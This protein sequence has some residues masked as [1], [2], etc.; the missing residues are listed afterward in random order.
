MNKSG[1]DNIKVRCRLVAK[2]FKVMSSLQLCH[3]EFITTLFLVMVCDK[4]DQDYELEIS[5]D[6]HGVP[7]GD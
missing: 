7:C 6:G 4:I 3:L 1:P 5:G 2:D